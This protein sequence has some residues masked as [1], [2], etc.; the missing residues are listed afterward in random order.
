MPQRVSLADPRI[1]PPILLIIA[2]IARL[3]ILGDPVVHID[4]QFYL[5]VGGRM[6]HGALPYV[7]IWDRKPIGL[8]LLF[9]GFRAL[10]G[11]GVVTYQ[12]AGL[13]SVWL[14]A[15]LLFAIGKRVSSP[16]G[17]LA[18][19]L[20]YIIWMDLA[21]GEGGQSPVYYNL[22]VAAAIAIVFFQRRR[23][24]AHAGDMRRAGGAAMLLFGIALQ[25]KYSAVFEGIFAGIML[26]WISWRGG[27]PLGKL[28][29]HAAIWIGCALLPTALAVGSYAYI[30]HFG[31]W[32][33]ANVTSILHRGAEAPGTTVK[34]VEVMATIVGPLLL[35]I[36]ARRWMHARPE[37]PA[38]R[39]DLRFVDAWAAA[40]LFGVAIFGT[41]FDHYALPLFAPLSVAAS[42]LWGKRWGKAWLIALLSCG[43]IWG[44][45]VLWRHTLSRGTGTTLE[46]AAAAV[47]G[48]K[49]CIFIYDGLPAL[50]DVTN[51]CLPTTRP[52]TAHLQS[53]N[54]MG[55]T[56]IDEPSEVARIMA[57]HPDRVMVAEPAYAEEN[58]RARAEL[59][60][61]L[62]PDYRQIY[63]RVGRHRDLVV[64]GLIGSASPTQRR[65]DVAGTGFL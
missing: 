44:Q 28:G 11:S 22:P 37:D 53:N 15:L 17:A 6:L 64:Y 39:E 51:S 19:A 36:A 2:L 43:A 45:H 18:G 9:A 16:A 25:I 41:W 3:Q 52:F 4:E 59:Y 54:E 62:G 32:W 63:R 61:K 46:A 56:G 65:L 23:A 20:I 33:F 27:R 1:A 24:T 10:G 30:G 5:L 48:H 57:L 58:L 60:R 47:H 29:L 55:A 26:L 13:V 40:A 38:A 14:T 50:Y 42:P 49:N 12:I 21:G 34:R 35:T 8:F 7:D 31:D